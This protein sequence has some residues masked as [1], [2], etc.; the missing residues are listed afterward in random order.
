[1]IVI[2]RR[3]YRVTPRNMQSLSEEGLV[4]FYRF[5]TTFDYFTEQFTKK[6]MTKMDFL[7]VKTVL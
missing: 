5:L 3:H 7:T 4:N 1:M 2:N 6:M